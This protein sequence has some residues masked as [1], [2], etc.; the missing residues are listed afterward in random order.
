M[1]NVPGARYVAISWTDGSGNLWLFGGQGYD[2][3]G[4]DGYLNDLWEYVP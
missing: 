3:S 1:S 4:S 2:S